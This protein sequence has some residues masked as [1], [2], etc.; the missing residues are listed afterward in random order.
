MSVPTNICCGTSALAVP[1]LT[2]WG[3]LDQSS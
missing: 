1:I 2:A 3:R